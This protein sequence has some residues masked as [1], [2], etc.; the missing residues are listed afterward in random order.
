MTPDN[1]DYFVAAYVA[2]AVVYGGYIVSLVV[3][4]RRA[5]GRQQRQRSAGEL[6]RT[7]RSEA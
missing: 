4:A 6:S 5:R 3:R 1:S 7:P 2:A